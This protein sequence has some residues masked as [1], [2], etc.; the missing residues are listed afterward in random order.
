MS[1]RSNLDHAQMVRHVVP[2]SLAMLST[3][4][5][6]NASQQGTVLRIGSAPA[7]SL[8]RRHQHPLSLSHLMM[9][10]RSNLDHAHMVRC[11]VPDSP[12]ILS[13]SGT[14]NAAQPGTALRI[15]SAA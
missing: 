14:R 8:A 15:G 4:G 5:T 3:S 10:A 1:A 11:A 12:A 2:D 9:S 6:R 13:T 7:T